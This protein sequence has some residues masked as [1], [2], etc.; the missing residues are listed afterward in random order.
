M[1]IV[2]LRHIA[3]AVEDI[4]VAIR[5]YVALGFRF[6]SGDEESGSFISGLLNLPD[7]A[8]RTA[9]LS[10]SDGN[11]LELI[12]FVTPSVSSHVNLPDIVS[13]GFHHFAVS[14]TDISAFIS[15][16]C[17]EGGSL[18]SEPRRVTPQHSENA[19]LAEHC[20]VADPFG[21]FIHVA[22]DCHDSAQVSKDR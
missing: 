17:R 13:L 5:F 7:C 3:L 6:E 4:D 10:L 15:L 12:Q 2:N 8:L 20:Y 1:N 9:K 16:V 18:V 11:R 21:N 19:V 22:Q 14:V